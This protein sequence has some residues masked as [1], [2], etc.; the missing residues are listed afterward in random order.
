MVRV[1]FAAVVVAAR[2]PF[3]CLT[4]LGIPCVR[5]AIVLAMRGALFVFWASALGLARV[6]MAVVGL[7]RKK[8]NKC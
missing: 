8:Q 2:T 6:A 4:C 3:L 7:I 1:R 5:I